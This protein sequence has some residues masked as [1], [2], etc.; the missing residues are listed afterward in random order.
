MCGAPL[1]AGGVCGAPLIAG[2]VCGAPLIAGG[3]CG[4][5][6]IAGGVCGAPLVAGGRDV[7]G[8]FSRKGLGA[9]GK[10]L[11]EARSAFDK[12][13]GSS[14]VESSREIARLKNSGLRQ[15]REEKEDDRRDTKC[16]VAR[17]GSLTFVLHPDGWLDSRLRVK[18]SFEQGLKITWLSAEYF[19][20]LKANPEAG[21]ILAL[22]S[23]VIFLW[24]GKVVRIEA[25]GN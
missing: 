13:S 22:G 23:R 15:H 25:P 3:V 4:V 7:R 8:K 14:A 12:D 18:K 2:R 9:A 11:P 24:E 6:L 16:T 17:V 1:I 10:P 20:F 19:E 21:K 5:P